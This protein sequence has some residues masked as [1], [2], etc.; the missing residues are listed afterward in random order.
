M[1]LNCFQIQ[2][3]VYFCFSLAFSAYA[4]SSSVEGTIEAL[5]VDGKIKV[6]ANNNPILAANSKCSQDSAL[7]ALPLASERFSEICK[8]II[9]SDIC[10]NEPPEKL[11]DCSKPENLNNPSF[12]EFR[13]GCAKGGLESVEQTLGFIGDLL[14]WSW[15]NAFSQEALEKVGKQGLEYSKILSLYLYSEYEKAYAIQ[16]PPFKEVKALKTLGGV[17]SRLILSRIEDYITKEKQKLS[18]YNFKAKSEE[19]CKAIGE[20]FIS[21]EAAIE[22]VKS[23]RV[24]AHELKKPVKKI[25]KIL[26]VKARQK[27]RVSPLSL[28]NDKPIVDHKGVEL[29]PSQISYSRLNTLDDRVRSNVEDQ[30]MSSPVA[31]SKKKISIGANSPMLVTFRDGTKGVWKP[32]REVWGSNYRAEV[33]AYELDKKFGF[34]LVPPTVERRLD[35]KIGSV[36]LYKIASQPT[37]DGRH[38]IHARRDELNKLSLFDYLID[39]RDRHGE[40]VLVDRRGKVI[41]IDNGD[42]F[43]GKGLNGRTF[44]SRVEE[45]N[46]FLNTPD[47]SRI[48]QKLKQADLSDLEKQAS[49]YLGT[50]DA[51][52]LRKRIEFIIRFYDNSKP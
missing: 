13:K 33:L 18:C 50:G 21:R 44:E 4:K 1:K 8:S 22:F 31:G 37:L 48:M 11:L 7:L 49:E 34:N 47:G 42:S 2:F 32:H 28:P 17:V 39:N 15:D 41:S 24:L 6:T 3:W 43:T 30:M 25:E 9:A 35:G 29:S 52:K 10:K 40:N 16:D 5:M 36:Q 46:K 23:G 38:L 45:I 27:N 19:Y 14:K 12:W 26:E 51:Q 20:I